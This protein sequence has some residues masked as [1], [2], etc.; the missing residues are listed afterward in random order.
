[1]RT[2][3]GERLENGEVRV[4]I[5]DPVDRPPIS[6]I[7]EVLAELN[8][9]TFNRDG[10]PEFQARRDA[11]MVRKNELV[12]RLEEAEARPESRP[13]PHLP[14][15]SPDGFEWGYDGNGPLDLA[16]AILRNELAV[17]PTDTVRRTFCREVV[18]R[19]PRARFRLPASDVVAWIGANRDLI[20]REQFL[21][22]DTP[23]HAVTAST[24]DQRP[25]P[26]G[27]EDGPGGAT[28]SAL[29]AACEA[30][31]DDIRSHHPELPDAVVILG[32]G[33]ER[34]RL[35][36]LGHWWGGRWVADGQSRGEVLIAGEALHLQPREVFEVLLHEAA[37]GINAHRRVRDTSRNG[38]YHNQLYAD[39]AREV[40]LD[41]RAM[42]PHGLA[43][44]S[45]TP[46]AEQRYGPTIERLGEAM[47]IARQLD[48]TVGAENSG[49][50]G[51]PSG[52]DRDRKRQATAASCG[53]GRRIRMAPSVLAAGPVLCGMC[54]TEFSTGAEPRSA[55][56]LAGERRQRGRTSLA[57]EALT[58]EGLEPGLLREVARQRDR[59]DTTIRTVVDRDPA[60]RDLLIERRDRLDRL[61]AHTTRVADPGTPSEPAHVVVAEWYQRYGTLDEQTIPA[62]DPFQQSR[63]QGLARDLLKADGT[64]TG[65]TVTIG[66][67]ELMAGDRVIVTADDLRSGVPEGLPGTVT[68]VDPALRTIDLDFETWGTLRTSTGGP[69]AR[70]LR[71]A[72]TELEATP[73][74]S[75]DP[76]PAIELEH[77]GPDIEP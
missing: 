34:G 64:L 48:G 55:E 9:L 56:F 57:G 67:T 28:A 12:R 14:G 49:E 47:R 30:A 71:H 61:L 21:D 40:L 54:G 4:R 73:R 66:R 26:A 50:P 20:D 5:V 37:H 77:P 44:T 24:D 29:I 25:G 69:V 39:A 16:A 31:W 62:D 35:V 60:L 76:T 13:L 52:R 32:T 1:M 46:A 19:L 18:A 58:P 75:T 72:Y 63:R 70:S 7:N 59:L 10:S 6:E 41:V 8:H 23:A 51:S 53:C 65:P 42:P 43:N 17:E 36:K 22:P 2:Y 38:R 45:L 3:V 33:V 27:E 11:Y 74:L 15:S 68:A